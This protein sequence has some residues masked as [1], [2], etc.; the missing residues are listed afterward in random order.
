MEGTYITKRDGGITYTWKGECGMQG[1]NW[2][3]RA[4]VW[5]DGV[6]AGDP[7]GML[8]NATYSFLE[9]PMVQMFVEAS[10]EARAGVQ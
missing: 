10:I 6:Y 1:A 5:R 2:H 3:W 7:G 8:L 4:R 9:Y